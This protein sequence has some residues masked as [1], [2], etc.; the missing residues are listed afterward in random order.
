MYLVPRQDLALYD[1]KMNGK[2]V[3]YRI[4]RFVLKDGSSLQGVIVEENEKSFIIKSELGFLTISRDKVSQGPFPPAGK[5]EIPARYASSNTVKFQSK[6]GVSMIGM[7]STH[8]DR[9]LVGFSFYFEPDGI[10]TPWNLKLGVRSEYAMSH[11]VDLFSNFL[12]I[13][14]YGS[15]FQLRTF[16][17]FGLGASYASYDSGYRNNSGVNPALFLEYGSDIFEWE[18]GFLRASLRNITVF[19]RTGVVFLP[20]MEISVGTFL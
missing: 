12:Y 5:P 19:E 7:G 3:S 17:N 8:F 15:L 1:P 13:R 14:T 2:D 18:T 10:V 6:I 20:G 16:L 9:G 4:S 11:E